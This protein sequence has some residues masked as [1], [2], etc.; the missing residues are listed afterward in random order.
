MLLLSLA[1]VAQDNP[2][3][4]FHP[5]MFP[6]YPSGA[7]LRLTFNGG[8]VAVGNS[9][10]V[11]QSGTVPLVPN[12]TNYVYLNQNIPS[13]QVS[14]TGYLTGSYPIATA[15]T[16]GTE[17]VTLTDQRPN[18]FIST[19]SGGTIT[20][21]TA[22]SGLS[23]GGASGTVAVSLVSCASGG[24]ILSWSGSGWNC[25]NQNAGTVTSVTLGTGL[26]GGTI[27]G[28]GTASIAP[29]YALPQSCGLN[30]VPEWN[31]VS[32]LWTCATG[33]GNVSTAPSTAQNIAQPCTGSPCQSTQTST[34]NLANIRYVTASWNWS[35]TDSGGS[36]GNLTSAGS[37]LTLTLPCT[38]S[39]PCPLGIDTASSSHN[40]TY[41]IYVSGTGTAEAA[42]VTSG[43]CTSGAQ[44]SCTLVV[45]TVNN[46]PNGYTIGSS[47]TGIQ[48]AWNDAWTSDTATTATNAAAPYVKLSAGTNYSVYSTVYMRGRG[49]VLDG[50]GAFIACST[51]DRCI[52]AGVGSGIGYHKLVTVTGGSTINVDG[53]QVSSVCAGTSCSPT[54]TAGTYLISTAS[55]H[56]FVVG[57]TVRCE[58]Y[59]QTASGSWNSKVVSVPSAT[60]FTVSFGTNNFAVG[61]NTFGFCG[62]Q[63]TFFEDNS[64]H[65]SVTDLNLTILNPTATGTFSYGIIADNDQDL[66]IVRAANRSTGVIKNSANFP[67]GAF[68][69][70]RT[71]QGNAALV[72]VL[73]TELTNVNCFDGGG[74]GAEWEGGVCQAFPVFGVRY[75]GSLV[76]ITIKDMYQSCGGVINP[77]YSG[78]LQGEMG[79]LMTGG[80]AGNRVLGTF[81]ICATAP[82]FASGGGAGALINYFICPKSSVA[83]AMPCFYAGNAEPASGAT[84]ITVQWPSI[85]LQNPFNNS[86]LGTVTYDI[87]KTTGTAVPPY[88]TGNFSNAFLEG[89]TQSSVCGTNGICSS[90]DAQSSL[91]SY[92]VPSSYGF[93][94]AFWWWPGA[95]VNN[96]TLPL[97]SDAGQTSAGVITTAGIAGVG[98][99]TPVCVPGGP[100]NGRSAYVTLSLAIT[101]VSCATVFNTLNG[102]STQTKGRLNFGQYPAEIPGDWLTIQDNNYSKTATTAGHRP[103]NDAGDMAFSLDQTGGFATRS[104]TSFSNYIGT[105]ADNSSY[106]ERLTSSEKL[107]GVPLSLANLNPGMSTVIDTNSTY[108]QLDSD[109]RYFNCS[110]SRYSGATL[111]VR[112]GKCWADVITNLGGIADARGITDASGLNEQIAKYTPINELVAPVLS[113]QS[114][115]TGTAY[116]SSAVVTVSYAITSPEGLS[117]ASVE[118]SITV[119]SSC[120]G[121]GNCFVQMATPTYPGTGTTYTPYFATSTGYAGLSCGAI[122]IGS[123]TA[124]GSGA[125][126]GTQVS[127]A[128]NKTSKFL[129]PSQ[130]TWTCTMTSSSA[131]ADCLGAMDH[132]IWLG[133]MP[134]SSNGLQITSQSTTSVSDALVGTDRNAKNASGVVDGGSTYVSL[135]GFT[136]ECPNTAATC[137]I[138]LRFSALGD[139]SK[140]ANVQVANIVGTAIS[141]Y[142]GGYIYLNNVHG[143]GLGTQN[144]NSV[145]VPMVIGK[146]GQSVQTSVYAD[147]LVLVHPGALNNTQAN[148]NYAGSNTN[149]IVGKLDMEG[150]GQS[151]CSNKWVDLCTSTTQSGII[152]FGAINVGADFTNDTGTIVNIRSNCNQVDI[153]ALLDGGQSTVT[154]ITDGTS[155]A[156]TATPYTELQCSKRTGGTGPCSFHTS[157]NA[158]AFA[159]GV[160]TPIIQAYGTQ[161]ITTSGG[162]GTVTAKVGASNGGSFT[163][164]TTSGTCTLTI[165]PAGPTPP[166][167]YY[168]SAHDL[169]TPTDTMPQTGTLSTSTC[170]LAGTIATGDLIVWT[171]E[172]SF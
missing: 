41:R 31:T 24:Q 48:E 110:S 26:A 167:G 99:V 59:S 18:I 28:T 119:D 69:L 15:L 14:I 89:L 172:K 3:D 96:S 156:A 112:L 123:T 64:D 84:V 82:Q 67:M 171:V 128:A 7:G 127:H 93:S 6:P 10:Y 118:A 145:G 109:Y 71:D 130:A 103:S 61:T 79:T 140:L 40:Y 81:P 115:G 9:I 52:M 149:L 147:N 104:A 16:N 72:H 56:P 154:A 101:N 32:S 138:A 133:D 170:T 68:I 143:D 53:V 77:L 8:T 63:N 131:Q 80:Q 42:T 165:T 108:G 27:T 85:Q 34:N 113:K 151:N 164:G 58:Y 20:G 95:L 11:I 33:L 43:T 30:Q 2:T 148:L 141:V 153:G 50:T 114:T 17:I 51:R 29:A 160:Y 5:Y 87:I 49:G 94:G 137:P 37:G 76:P 163:A 78:S 75:F 144:A 135:S 122:A 35:Y 162:C 66:H 46:H 19:G 146:T 126:A 134:G 23:G 12:A 98:L 54:Q 125:C 57:D 169:T 65:V 124:F 90:T 92:T 155:F 13:V 106:L 150:C 97:I 107:I 62:I 120:P 4:P 45:T 1:A 136:V 139:S 152:W 157:Q 129:L 121:T 39:A 74:N 36:L 117:D 132:G 55:D 88:G 38:T 158:A 161:S 91:A 111:D 21:V 168:C 83:G 159:N 70:Q 105:V 60:S 25:T 142:S 22:G 116:G 100:S 166:N 44:A 86:S 102:G 73:D 47:S